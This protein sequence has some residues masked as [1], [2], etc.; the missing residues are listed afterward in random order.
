MVNYVRA[1]YYLHCMKRRAFWSRDKLKA[2]QDERLRKIVRYAYDHVPLYHEKFRKAGIKPSDVKGVEDLKKIPVLRKDEVRKNLDRMVSIDYDIAKLKVLRT[3]GSTGQPLRI[4][5]TNAEDELRKAKHLRANIA[6]GQRIR[7]R[8]ITITSP[9]HFGETTRLQRILGFYVP[10]PVSVFLDTA[11]QVSFIGR[12]KP[13]VLD[14]YSSSLLLLAKE[15]KRRGIETIRPRFI[16]GGSELIGDS[17]CQFIEKVF[18]APFYDQYS[19]VEMERLAWQCPEKIGYHMDV[20]TIIMQFVDKNGDEVSAGEKGEI[21]CTSLFNYAMPFIRYAVGDVGALLNDECVCGRKLPLMK[22]IEGRRDSFV[23][24][25]NGKVFS[26]RAFTVAIGMFKWYDHI[27]QFRIVQRKIDF[28]EVYI[29]M[30]DGGVNENVLA[31]ELVAHLK[32]SLN[33]E[34]ETVDFKVRFVD[35]IPLDKSGKLMIVLSKLDESVCT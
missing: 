7:D 8:W 33:I 16:I 25:P 11:T 21:I 5:L 27:E 24:L 23:L 13:D 14:G 9:F 15:V 2:H 29:K 35:D 32:K 30:G 31:T 1:Y 19:C 10:I 12:M 34:D 17:S 18:D 28:L 20:D 4:Y 22:P 6:C 3:S 26:P